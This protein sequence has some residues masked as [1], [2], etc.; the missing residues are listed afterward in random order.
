[1]T[2]PFATNTAVAKPAPAGK[3]TDPFATGTSA[4]PTPKPVATQTLTLPKNNL[5][6]TEKGYGAS[7][8]TDPYS[9]KPLATVPL[10]IPATYQTPEQTLS[11]TDPTRVATSFDPTVP[12]KIDRSM[13][14]NERLPSSASSKIKAS[15]GGNYSEELDHKIALELSGSNTE[16][17]L[18]LE[19][20]IPGTKNTATDPLE[21][22]L[23]HDVV[24][25]KRSLVDAQIT[26]AQA[27]GFTLP[28]DQSRSL[29]QSIQDNVLKSKTLMTNP[30][31]KGV[32]SLQE[33]VEKVGNFFSNLA[34][35]LYN[36]FAKPSPSEQEIE[37][38]FVPD[39][40]KTGSNLLD[41]GI[42]VATFLPRTLLK[43]FVRLYEPFVEPLGKDIGGTIAG[44]Q[45]LSKYK[46]GDIT[47]QKASDLIS[48]LGV[49]G[50]TNLQI[51]GDVT[52]GVLSM[53]TP[54]TAGDILGVGETAEETAAEITA[55]AGQGITQRIGSGIVSGGI[56][57][58]PVATGFGVGQALSSGS[59]DPK[60]IASI[61]GQNLAAGLLLGGLTG[62]ATGG[63][64]R[65]L[66]VDEAIDQISKLRDQAKSPEVKTI[67]DSTLEHL[68]DKKMISEIKPDTGETSNLA[69]T[70]KSTQIAS[71]AKTETA[72]PPTREAAADRYYNELIKPKLDKGEAT[73]ISSDDVKDLHSDYSHENEKIYSHAAQD[74][75]ERTL[76]ENK[77]PRFTFVG[78][79]S[80]SGKTEFLTKSL[81]EDGHKGTIYES[82][83][84]N[85]DFV[86]KVLE[87]AQAAGKTPDAYVI[88]SD[89]GEARK[90]T[91]DRQ[92][93]KGRDVTTDFHVKSHSG[94]LESAKRLAE[95]DIEVH[96]IDGRGLD[97]DA[98]RAKIIS[99][100]PRANP[101]DTLSKIDHNKE[102]VLKKTLE[103]EK[104]YV[105]DLHKQ[106]GEGKGVSDSELRK[107]SVPLQGEERG[108]SK[109]ATDTRESSGR[110]LR[111]KEAG[112]A[113]SE[114]VKKPSAEGGFVK[115][116]DLVPK[117]VK[118]IGSEIR[119][120]A[121]PQT[122]SP[123]ATETA[124]II[125]NAKADIANTS[126]IERLKYKD[127]SKTFK[128]ATDAENIGNISEYEKTGK[129]KNAPAGYSD[130]FKK[131]MDASRAILQETYGDNRV[132]YVENYVRRAFEFGSK[133]DEEKGTT[134]LTNKTNS[135]SASKSNI[136][137][138]VL[139]MPL[140]EA[141]ADMKARGIDV[142]PATTNPELLRQ[143]SVE[144][145]KQASS[146]KEVWDSAKEKGLVQFVK[147]G[148]RA[149]ENMVVLN[150]RVAKVF[151]PTDEG[152]VK[153]GEYYADKN[154]ARV[155]NNTISRG[156]GDSA[157]YKGIRAINN[158]YN[159]FQLGFSAFHAVGT[160]INSSI[161]D[162]SLG[163]RQILNGDFKE[164]AASV[165]KGLI[166]G[167]SF[168]KNLIKANGFLSD[169]AN[170][171][172]AAKKTLDEIVNPAGAR[173]RLE[174]QY[175]N[176][177]Y[178]NMMQAWKDSSAAFK[179][180]KTIEAGNRALVGATRLPMAI[181]EKVASPLMEYGIPRV[182]IGAFLNLAEATIA[183]LPED[184]S[185][186]VRARAL[187]ESWDSIDNRFGQVVYDNLFWNKTLKDLTTIATRSV[188]W[189]L[190]TVREL[191]GGLSDILTK[192]L[193]GKGIS[194][195]T[196]YTAML[197]LY[198]GALG[199]AYQYLHT[200][201]GPSELKD[202][203]YPKNGLTDKNGNPDRSSLPTYMKDVYAY[204]T[205]PLSTVEHKASPLASLMTELVTNRDYY[206]DMILNPA[207]SKMKQL[208]QAGS[209][210]LNQ[211]LPFTAQNIKQVA[212]EN[213]GITQKIEPFLGITKA[214]ASI[215][216]SAKQQ[217]GNA[218]ITQKRGAF[219]PRTPEQ[220]DIANQKTDARNAAAKGD[221]SK[222]NA[223]IKMG[224]ISPKS[225][226]KFIKDS[227]LTPYQRGLESLP[228]AQRKQ[229]T[230]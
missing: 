184:S 2:D 152:M 53:L 27:K 162:L 84:S 35:G 188:G 193:R 52:T 142:K 155:F 149:P 10:K 157:T 228:K 8:M 161:S 141:L 147:Q 227:K 37:K 96:V 116:S 46:N 15:L 57:A 43:G 80:G 98:I 69:E 40:P 190:G 198:V 32:A 36:Q 41:K 145:A 229:Y 139:D 185:P 50:K 108:N 160:A 136:K 225:R 70:P 68:Q 55:R 85:P 58:L 211:F 222:L 72:K 34:T 183:K 187:A 171:S 114:I 73:V 153:A 28:D 92:K 83:M 87:K 106:T 9:G 212:S 56:S 97:R 6:F 109:G 219:A 159:Q 214:P 93:E 30:V 31:M 163:A 77:N 79:G 16:A 169:L 172:P 81:V 17:N 71:E 7:T 191:G 19:P 174:E 61:V 197:P 125:R 62:G 90:F 133:A 226:A 217:A 112:S 168:A 230:Q 51:L 120:G 104:Q 177:A 26:L 132:G 88:V 105:R 67:M 78:G 131:S 49:A 63:L 140:D 144:N 23:A 100:E 29:V 151:F 1:M 130:F 167:Y 158:A 13:L 66:S 181:V 21:N 119:G 220:V 134:Y 173:L 205:D 196:L 126:A 25:G 138:R 18:Q 115:P 107:E 65:P 170:D 3:M 22:Q 113:E 208:G 123:R 209:Y 216:Q 150:D 99:K 178:K 82:T 111:R 101:I 45:I 137:G 154:V 95:K 148:G 128:K 204:S 223:M 39:Q 86:S 47:A 74:V 33:G 121:S 182:K 24:S 118:E 200:G 91:L 206:G 156:L 110:I 201:K 127:I 210:V 64:S 129:F 124:D 192:T 102:T 54:E 176:S 146:Y 186:E 103:A 89:P 164:G 14:T 42:A 44:N 76:K 5:D 224:I 165:T 75:L 221:Y 117:S 194:D 94:Y 203:F 143:W 199:A 213:G 20:D 38:G 218:A 175:S 189:N 180:G 202:Y 12:Q 166:P 60:E 48:D 135:L 59:T 195:R 215:T 122:A 11:V 207:D 4:I 179:E